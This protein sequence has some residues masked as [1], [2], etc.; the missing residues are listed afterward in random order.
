MACVTVFGAPNYSLWDIY[1]R[2]RGFI[3][4]PTWRLY[5]EMLTTDLA[6]LGADFKVPLYFFQRADDELTVTAVTKQYFE[7]IN[8]PRK[9]MVLFKDAGHFAVWSMS[10]KFLQELVARVRPLAMQP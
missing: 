5:H 3:Q 7:K 8:A 1:N 10:D 9:E 4:V 6:S 2:Y